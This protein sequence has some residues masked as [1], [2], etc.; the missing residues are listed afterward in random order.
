MLKKANNCPFCGSDNIQFSSK[1]MQSRRHVIQR[2]NAM[3]CEECRCY[4][5]RLIVVLTDNESYR[6]IDSEKYINP[7]IDAWNKRTSHD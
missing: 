5:P 7:A 1:T 4:G 2:H 6:D 3:Y